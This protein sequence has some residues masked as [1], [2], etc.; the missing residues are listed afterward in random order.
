MSS[1]RYLDEQGVT[2]TCGLRETANCERPAVTTLSE[3]ILRNINSI[4]TR[5]APICKLLSVNPRGYD[6]IARSMHVN[7]LR[8][9]SC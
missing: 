6:D 4:M 7:K 3:M 9:I 2:E 1:L 5:K 8:E